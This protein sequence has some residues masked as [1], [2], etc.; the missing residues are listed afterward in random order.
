MASSAGRVTLNE[1]G[2][3]TA[4]ETVGGPASPTDVSAPPP[5][6]LGLRIRTAR[7]AS[8]DTLRGFARRLGVSPSL[9]SQI[10]RDRVMPSVATL[11]SIASELGSSMDDLIHDESSDGAR[12]T[13][14][15]RSLVQRHDTRHA[16]SLS[17]GVTWEQLA[18]SPDDEVEFLHVKYEPGAASAAEDSLIRHGGREYGIVT[19]GVLGVRVGFEDFELGPGDSIVFDSRLPHRLWTIGDEP[20]TAIWFVV[21]RHGDTRAGMKPAG[22]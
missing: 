7:V 4:P 5:G 22:R 1:M 19:G 21:N 2:D 6:T 8:G 16:I 20:A 15:R 3:L 14:A 10:E 12:Q 13:R 18:P 9:I 17:G 11:Y